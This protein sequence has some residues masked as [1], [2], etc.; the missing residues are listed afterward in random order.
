MEEPVSKKRKVM[1]LC[2]LAL[3]GADAARAW[4]QEAEK[5]KDDK[6]KK[7]GWTNS[8]D[9]SLVVTTGNSTAQTLGLV[10]RLRYA[11]PDA[12]F[13]FDASGVHTNKSDD[14]YF[15]VE[16]GQEF[17]VGA[18]PS[19]SSTTLIKPEPTTDV[20]TFLVSS[21][22]DKNITPQVFWN[23]G[24]SWDHNKDAGIRSRYVAF[25]GIGNT[26]ADN[27]R[28]HF[29]TTY[30]L[31]YTDRTEEKPDPEKEPRFAGARLDWD[32]TEH[33]GK[34]TTLDSDFITNIDLADTADFS[35]NT[36]N[37][38]TVS[39]NGHLS[40]KVSLQWLFENQPALE[41]DLDVVAFVELVNPD[42]IPSS[43][44]ERFRTLATGGTKL[45]LGKA[46]A[47]KDKLNTIFRTS[48][49]ITF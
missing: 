46:D 29:A 23:A 27:K 7:L 11:W 2:L 36:T 26:W 17:A 22:Y 5:G 45:V 30:G 24:L 49:V 20:A 9:F 43:G 3:L 4:A 28:R 15:L 13:S 37:G 25:A 35:I 21:R 40:L 19:S 1:A 33:L 8:T 14:R 44:D 34:S 47:R 12:R 16:P 31:S 10:D 32:Y 18:Q 39:M 42:G 6:E 38:V 48:L 41:T